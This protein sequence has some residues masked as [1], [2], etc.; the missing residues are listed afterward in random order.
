MRLALRMRL[1]IRLADWQIGFFNIMQ[2][3]IH[4]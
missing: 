1:A 3:K 4:R 2:V